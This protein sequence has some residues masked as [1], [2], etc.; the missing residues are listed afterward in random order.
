MDILIQLIKQFL[1][2]TP[3]SLLLVSIYQDSMLL[4]QAQYQMTL[5]LPLK[6]QQQTLLSCLQYILQIVIGKLFSWIMFLIVC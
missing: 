3:Q 2:L 1:Q 5:T 4:L 6:L